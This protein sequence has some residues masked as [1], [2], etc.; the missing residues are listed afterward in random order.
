MTVRNH[1]YILFQ[2]EGEGGEPDPE[3]KEG[4]IEPAEDEKKSAGEPDPEKEKEEGKKKERGTWRAQLPAE[5]KDNE[6][7]QDLD[8][9]GALAKAYIE[10]SDKPGPPEK[11][12]QY[13]Y[14][15]ELPE[16]IQ[17]DDARKSDW[18]SDIKNLKEFFHSLALT[19][20][21][22]TGILKMWIDRS[23]NAIKEQNKLVS[24]KQEKLKEDWGKDQEKN[25]E[26]ANRAH[27][28]ITQDE[29]AHQDVKEMA[30]VLISTP[31]GQRL[32]H[33]I[34]ASYIVEPNIKEGEIAKEK[35]KNVLD[36]VYP[37]MQ[38]ETHKERKG[39]VPNKP[40][41]ESVPD[42]YSTIED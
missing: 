2:K 14:A 24:E 12:E 35:K 37:T 1:N 39:G 15:L 11:A 23:V 10:F 7:L 38:G 41:P 6:K 40:K 27:N 20:G 9:V 25:S 29:K 28:S 32:L 3:K 22:A 33:Y 8:T 26:I 36:N 21:Q 13:S 16:D 42:I 30:A 4:E 31:S 17:I 19:D 18:Q 5:L 34:G